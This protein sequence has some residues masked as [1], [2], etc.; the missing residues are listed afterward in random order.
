M[1]KGLV[2]GLVVVGVIL[3]A[4]LAIGGWFVG[5]R[6]DLVGLEEGVNSAASQVQ[7]VYQRRADLIP[8]LVE[9][10]KGYAAH[11]QDTLTQVTEARA[12]VN[13]INL[14]DAVNDPSKMNQ[15]MKSQGE[16]SSA[17]SRLMV[18]VERYPDLKA[19]ENFRD[20]QVQLEGTENRIAVERKRFNDSAQVFNT[21]IRQ[22]PASLVA[23]M[24]GFNSKAYFQAEA[25]AEKAPEVKFGQ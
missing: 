9:T 19:N 10:V 8:N 13:N 25:G 1:R 14:G 11:E 22:F 6:N 2:A 24:S 16:L 23:S 12:K 15:F 3:L 20:L 18:V 7:N 17:L 21:R 4:G 5:T